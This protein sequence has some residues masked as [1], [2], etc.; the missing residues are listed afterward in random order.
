MSRLDSSDGWDPVDALTEGGDIGRAGPL[1]R[2][3]EVRLGVVDAVRFVELEGPQQQRGIQ[4]PDRRKR[5]NGWNRPRHVFAR[6]FGEGLEHGD[7]PG[8]DEVGEEQFVH[9]R[10]DAAAGAARSG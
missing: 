6:R 7:R 1:G 8:N 4:G 3:D 10:Q 2:G 9:G 5:H